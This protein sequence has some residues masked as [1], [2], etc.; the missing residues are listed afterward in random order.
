MTNYLRLALQIRRDLH[1]GRAAERDDV[2]EVFAD[3]VRVDVGGGDELHPRFAQQKARDFRADR[4]NSVLRN[5][6]RLHWIH[7]GAL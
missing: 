3:F 2:A 4:A 5:G 1:A 6:D 7:G